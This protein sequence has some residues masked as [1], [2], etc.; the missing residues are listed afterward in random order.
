MTYKY[1]VFTQYLQ[2]R[3]HEARPPSAKLSTIITYIAH[4]WLCFSMP[5]QLS[6]LGCPQYTAKGGNATMTSRLKGW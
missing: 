2:Y 1:S 5:P 3:V 6:C 4:I